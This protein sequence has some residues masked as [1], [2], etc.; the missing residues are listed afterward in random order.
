VIAIAR[1]S[2]R[3]RLRCAD[4]LVKLIDK[5]SNVDMGIWSI[6]EVQIEFDLW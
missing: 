5:K 2:L 1:L 4:F 6:Y 3:G